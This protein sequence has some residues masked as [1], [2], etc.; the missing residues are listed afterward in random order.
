M[1]NTVIQLKN[2]GFSANV[3]TSLANGE[4]ALNFADGK[5]YYKN[6]TG[7]IITFVATGNIVGF[8][9][10]NAN[11]SLVTAPT[12]N[13][14]L[15][16]TPGNNIGITADIV[17]DIVTISAN[18]KP[19]FDVANAAFGKANTALQNATGTF[20]GALTT[21]GTITANSVV[22]INPVGGQEGGEMQLLATGANTNWTIDSYQNNYRIFAAT[23]STVS[24][25]NMFHSQAG[26]TIRLGVNRADPGYTV[27][28]NGTVNASAIYVNGSPL[29]AGSMDYAYV[30]TSTAAAN[31]Y[32]GV[33]ANN[34]GTI[35]NS[36]FGSANN[37]LSNTSGVSFAG[38]LYFPLGSSVGIGTTSPRTQIEII[39]SSTYSALTLNVGSG[40]ANTRVYDI[41]GSTSN[42]IS[43]RFVNELYTVGTAYYTVNRELMNI[44]SQVWYAGTGTEAMRISNTGNVGIGTT[45]PNESLTVCDNTTNNNSSI[46]TGTIARFI[47][48]DGVQGRIILDAYGAGTNMTFRQAGGTAAIPTATLS[49][50]SLLQLNGFGY[51]TTGYTNTTRV[52]MY[53]V[54][55]ENWTDTAQGTYIAFFTTAGG[56]LT[57]SEKVRIDANGNLGIGTASPTY[58]LDVNGSVNASALLVNGVA[59]GGGSTIGNETAS[60]STFYPVFTTTT[61][62]TMSSANVTTTKLTFIP[63]TGTLSATIY[64]STSD[65]KLKENIHSFDGIELLNQINP[66]S[67]TWKDSQSKSYGVIAQELEEVLPELVDTNVDGMKSVSYIPMIAMLIDVVKKQQKEIEEIKSLLNAK[68]L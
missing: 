5:L 9:T 26:G 10:V 67:F 60:A 16:L 52:G 56:S 14:I 47:G 19:A 51:G 68:Q 8:S 25:V 4:V 45:T 46:L 64:N 31:N 63:S 50:V 24:N 33:L 39:G 61:S 49:G 12:N 36:A 41:I 53:G 40:I 3:P 48:T 34:A 21:T 42:N 2:S 22:Y 7:Q 28:V 37:R 32:A 17:N 57:T 27:D 35:A 55:T 58:K 62:G 29:G 38:S 30:N 20:A 66:V 44:S 23:G 15:T 11:N 18:L 1:A 54:A 13:S 65:V 59:V 6:N 43:Y